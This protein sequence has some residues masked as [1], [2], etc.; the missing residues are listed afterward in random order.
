MIRKFFL[1]AFSLPAM[2][3]LALAVGSIVLFVVAKGYLDASYMASN[4]PVD[5][6]T[7]QTG[8]DGTLIKGYYAHMQKMGT[9]GVYWTTQF[10]DFS[11]IAGMFSMGLFALS[12][13]ARLARP[14]SV[15][16]KAGLM[17]SAALMT[18]AV[19]DVIENLISFVML[20]MPND[21]PD[22]IA[23]PYSAFAV[24]KFAL[25][26]TGML[27]GATTILLIIVARLFSKPKLG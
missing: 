19:S 15:G 18:G 13:I 12:G 14:A 4:H 26:T 2:V 22:W 10:I 5:Y 20:A 21:F 1:F 25:V 27:L 23:L 7:G 3:H 24:V 17:A 16:R 9:L 6:A 8:F 11:F